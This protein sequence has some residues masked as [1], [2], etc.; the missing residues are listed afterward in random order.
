MKTPFHLTPNATPQF[1][2]WQNDLKPIV[3]NLYALGDPSLISSRAKIAIVGSR[4]ISDYGLQILKIIVP[5][6]VKRKITIVSGGAFGVDYNAQQIAL[7]Y[8]GKVI[9]VLGSGIENPT[10]RTNL[11]FFQQ[12][13][14]KG[15]L[16]SEDPG[17]SIATKYTFVKRN[18]I[19]AGLADLI[20]IVEARQ[21]S[22]SLI[23]A[24][25][26]LQQN[27]PICC[28]PG[29]AFDYLSKG[30]NNLIK[31]GAYL[32]DSVDEII[33]LLPTNSQLS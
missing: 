9:T 20:L 8:S 14:T 26:A 1:F 29:R 13:A 24:D 22:G 19:I 3:E 7:N 25:Y 16:I 4:V 30:T 28:F 18:R 31:D 2:Q 23:T 11:D 33:N 6:L 21:K 27:K 17:K 10:P 32:V 15:L 12:V 5:E